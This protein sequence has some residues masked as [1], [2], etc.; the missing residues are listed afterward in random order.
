MDLARDADGLTH[1][2]SWLSHYWSSIIVFA[3]LGT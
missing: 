1:R 2:P 3:T